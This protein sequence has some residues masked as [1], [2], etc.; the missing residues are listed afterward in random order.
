MVSLN[1]TVDTVRVHNITVVITVYC[2]SSPGSDTTTVLVSWY[3]SF[4]TPSCAFALPINSALPVCYTLPDHLHVQGVRHLHVQGAMNPALG[5]ETLYYR[6]EAEKNGSQL[7]H[8]VHYKKGK[9][10]WKNT[11]LGNR[12]LERWKNKAAVTTNSP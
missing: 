4:H 6:C 7:F 5:E 10:P 11:K 8:C 12:G 2:T 3:R 9:P 1:Y